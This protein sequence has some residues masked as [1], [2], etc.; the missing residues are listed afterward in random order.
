MKKNIS[1]EEILQTCSSQTIQEAIFACS[2][3]KKAFE[4]SEND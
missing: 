2:S 1:G 4:K 3:L